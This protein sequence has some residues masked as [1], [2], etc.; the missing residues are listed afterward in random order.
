[1]SASTGGSLAR[2]DQVDRDRS[3]SCDGKRVYLERTQAE[4]AALHSTEDRREIFQ[5]YPCRHCGGYHIGHAPRQIMQEFTRAC[6]HVQ[7]SIWTVGDSAQAERYRATPCAGCREPVITFASGWG[8][9][10]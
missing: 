10:R 6:G 1:M 7:R 3:R 5:A 2:A 4:Y 9:T 8:R